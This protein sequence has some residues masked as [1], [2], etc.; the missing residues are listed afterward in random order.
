VA[1]TVAVVPEPSRREARERELAF[2]NLRGVRP[3]RGAQGARGVIPVG[4][5][6]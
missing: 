2:D 1:Y 4:G 3:A 6:A 5:I